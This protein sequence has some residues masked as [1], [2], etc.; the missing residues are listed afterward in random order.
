MTD[1]SV[2]EAGG[3]QEV[4]APEQGAAARPPLTQRVAGA[5]RDMIVQD[6]LKPGER[7][8]ERILADGLNVSRTP[9]REALKLLSAEGLV[10]ILPH[11]GAVVANPRPEEIFGKLQVLGV[12]ESLA[13][14]LAAVQAS[15]EEIAEIRALHFEMLASYARKNRLEYFKVNQKI[16]RAILCCSRN[17]AL[18][19]THG[20]INA[21]LYR[22]RYQ[23]NLR[24]QKWHGAIEEHE[25]ILAALEGRDSKQLSGLLR[26]H[27]GSTWAKVSEMLEA[28]SSN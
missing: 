18:I 9:L 20:R 24:N 22:V 1:A 25:K 2:P 3:K 15:D 19:E 7:I 27:L 5:I 6:E 28:S 26:A 13:G 8:R 10:E 16:H 23:S 14:E 4:S 12:L 21:Q 17:D 11:R